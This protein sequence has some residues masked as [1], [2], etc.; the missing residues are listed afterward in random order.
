MSK[1]QTIEWGNWQPVEEFTDLPKVTL[2]TSTRARKDCQPLCILETNN[3]NIWGGRKQILPVGDLCLQ[4][5]YNLCC[6]WWMDAWIPFTTFLR[7]TLLLQHLN[8]ET[9]SSSR[10]TRTVSSLVKPSS[11]LPGCWPFPSGL[12]QHWVHAFSLAPVTCTEVKLLDCG[13]FLNVYF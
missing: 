13:F 9:V 5:I 3:K 6:R 1:T 8:M 11:P 7:I 10:P 2:L 4:A 12:L